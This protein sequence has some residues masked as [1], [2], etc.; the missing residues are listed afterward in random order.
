MTKKIKEYKPV[1]MIKQLPAL[2]KDYKRKNE[3]GGRYIPVT[4]IGRGLVHNI[5]AP[6]ERGIESIHDI[7]ILFVPNGSQL[8]LTINEYDETA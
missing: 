7:S 2:R 8:T 5:T 3:A 6:W 1:G 4:Y